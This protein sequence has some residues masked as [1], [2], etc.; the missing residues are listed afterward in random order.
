[1]SENQDVPKKR[2][3]RVRG[4]FEKEPGS[5]VWWIRYADANGTLHR[6]KV[7]PKG[8]ARKVY[9]KRKT[10]VRER[11]FFPEQIGKRDALL[12]EVI[13]DHLVRVKGK[14]RSYRDC[15]RNAETWKRAFK[16]RTL[17]QIVPGDVERCVAKRLESVAPAS[18]NRELAFLKR[19]FNVAIADG[20]ADSNPVRSVKMFKENN[21]RV[22]FLAEEEETRLRAILNADQW[23]IVAVA[24]HTGLRQSEQF[25]LRWE[26]VD[27][28]NGVITI[29]R[30]KS[31]ELRR[32]P[33]NDAVR[34][35]LRAQPSRLK[36]E[37]VFPSSTGETPLDARNFVR[38]VF[39][40]A[41]ERGEIEGFRWHDLRHTFASRLVMAGVDLRTVQELMGH[42]T[43]NMTLRYSHL[44]PKHQFDAV[45]LLVGS[46]SG[47]GT[48][49]GTKA[50]DTPRE[51][52]AKA[53]ESIGLSGATRRSRTDDLLITNQLLY[54]LS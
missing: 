42:K 49:T 2:S 50:G 11:R 5:G 12:S 23:P 47:T 35:F 4:I 21:Q 16:D 33:M 13:D 37:Y 51:N 41:L 10:E 29:P 36:G 24:I 34:E 48:D 28:A 6:E 53:V 45:Q 22:R 15:A 25:N 3:G 26:T 43:I 52:L 40:P 31:G 32:V 17:R 44:S 8:L 20:L 38:R 9:E 7:G 39:L 14:L 54:Q 1:M 27:F 18:V 30:S 46:T 19:V